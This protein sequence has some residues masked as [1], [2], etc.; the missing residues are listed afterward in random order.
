MGK[1]LTSVQWAETSLWEPMSRIGAK[2]RRENTKE[3]HY[4]LG[5]KAFVKI[6]GFGSHTFHRFTF[7]IVCKTNSYI[8]YILAAFPERMEN[9]WNSVHFIQCTKTVLDSDH[10]LQNA[11]S[12]VCLASPTFSWEEISIPSCIR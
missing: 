9:L 7:E 10:I 2:P 1:Q 4:A 6:L 12:P 3:K 8:L 11:H 5:S